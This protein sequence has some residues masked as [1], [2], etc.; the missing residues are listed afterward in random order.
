M[1]EFGELIENNKQY[2]ELI[3]QEQ[4]CASFLFSSPDEVFVTNFSYMFA[5]FLLCGGGE[6]P[7]KECESCKKADLL[8]HSDLLIYPKNHKGILVEDVKNIIEKVYLAPIESDKKVFVLNNFSLATVQSQN[9]LLKILEEPPK[10]VYF[11]L[12]VTNE[13]KVLPTIFSRCKK[14]RLNKLSDEEIVSA[15]GQNATESVLD[16]ASGDLTKAIN[17]ASDKNFVECYSACLDTLKNMKD[18]KSVLNFSTRLVSKKGEIGTV[19]VVLESFYRDILL[20][21]LKTENL[22]KN[23]N[24]LVEL[25]DIAQ[26]YDADA[27]DKIIKKLYETKR[28]VDFNC[29]E[30]Y[31]IDN[32]LLYILE[33]K[34]LCKL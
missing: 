9:K 22:V 30:S 1:I 28:A 12:G 27:I 11:I 21:R 18:S 19:L 4:N 7:C 2:K 25:R 14:I 26:D 10:N 3:T 32:L 15:L 29:N 16:L 6:K 8:S 33:V 13:S 20:I 17:F 23:K 34:Y 5:K 24:I 31:L